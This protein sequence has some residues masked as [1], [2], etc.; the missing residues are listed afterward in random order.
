[1]PHGA[2]RWRAEHDKQGYDTI[3]PISAAAREAIE[4]YLRKTPR[5]GD[6]WLFPAPRCDTAPL[7]GDLAGKWLVRAERLAGLPKL[8]RGRWH[9]YRR[10]WAT[11]R[12]HLPTVDVAAAGGWKDIGTLRLSYQHADPETTLRVLEAGAQKRPVS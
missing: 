12:K 4:V 6:A 7:R 8:E 2:I 1:M 5:V 10:A 9:P 3:A 11:A